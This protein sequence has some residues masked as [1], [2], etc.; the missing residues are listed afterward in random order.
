MSS[1]DFDMDV[2][3]SLATLKEAGHVIGPASLN[4]GKVYIAIDRV[5]RTFDEIFQMAE[6]SNPRSRRQSA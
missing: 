4:Q 1:E 5:P 6:V 3:V 2:E